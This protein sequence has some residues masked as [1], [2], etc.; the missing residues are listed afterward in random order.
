[1]KGQRITLENSYLYSVWPVLMSCF[2]KSIAFCILLWLSA[3]SLL[4]FPLHTYSNIRWNMNRAPYQILFRN[5][6]KTLGVNSFS[7]IYSIWELFY[8][9]CKLQYISRAKTRVNTFYSNGKYLQ[10]IIMMSEIYVASDSKTI[11]PKRFAPITVRAKQQAIKRT[12]LNKIRTRK[13]VINEHQFK[14]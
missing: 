10:I 2:K 1:M 4:H 9:S 13:Q 11:A 14:R 6:S 3:E 12:K 5:L 8:Q 7:L